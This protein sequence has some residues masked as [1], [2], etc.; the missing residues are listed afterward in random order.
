MQSHQHSILHSPP[1]KSTPS[2]SVST[3]FA[4]ASARRKSAEAS[5]A[6]A[7]ALDDGHERE[8]RGGGIGSVRAGGLGVWVQT[9]AEHS[10]LYLLCKEERLRK[11]RYID[12]FKILFL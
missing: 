2:T 7:E 9:N 8:T 11:F 5:K 1:A 4:A 12:R 6:E 3:S 10:L